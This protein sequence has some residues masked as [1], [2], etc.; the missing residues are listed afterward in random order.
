MT[1]LQFWLVKRFYWSIALF[2]YFRFTEIPV[3]EWIDN[4][5]QWITWL[6]RIHVSL[7]LLLFTESLVKLKGCIASLTLLTLDHYLGS[8][9]PIRSLT[10]PRHITSQSFTTALNTM[11]IHDLLNRWAFKL[12]SSSEI[13]SQTW[14]DCQFD[15]GK[16]R[17]TRGH[18]NC[19]RKHRG[20]E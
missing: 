6:L 3:V 10:D 1:G 2:F 19:I 11:D 17:S 13:V 4:C 8:Q 18:W 14:L 5:A 7:Q 20:D 15:A 12:A 9:S 16:L